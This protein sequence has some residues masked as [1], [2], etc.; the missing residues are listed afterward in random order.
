[1]C[2]LEVVCYDSASL[3]IEV[4]FLRVVHVCYGSV[5][6]TVGVSFQNKSVQ[7]WMS[8]F[9]D[10]VLGKMFCYWRRW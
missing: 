6:R 8:V 4:V 5:S 1:M 3:S 7:A 9:C 2:F 10:S